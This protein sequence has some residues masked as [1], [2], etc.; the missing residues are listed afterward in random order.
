MTAPMAAGISATRNPRGAIATFI[1]ALHNPARIVRKLWHTA[2][3]G[4]R[5]AAGARSHGGSD[6]VTLLGV[7]PSGTARHPVLDRPPT[8]TPTT[9]RRKPSLESGRDWRRGAHAITRRHTAP[10]RTCVVVNARK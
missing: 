3:G 5:A 1:P 8:V 7:R 9:E 2:A 6:R 10:A 4:A